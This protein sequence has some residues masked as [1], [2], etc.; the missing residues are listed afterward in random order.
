MNK[1][2]SYVFSHFSSRKAAGVR[3]QRPPETG[4]SSIRAVYPSFFSGITPCIHHATDIIS[5]RF[6]LAIKKLLI[7]ITNKLEIS[8]NIVL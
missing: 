1:A 8:W 5:K 7:I 3:G 2:F 6:N 4:L